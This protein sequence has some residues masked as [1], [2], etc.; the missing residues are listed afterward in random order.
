MRRRVACVCGTRPEVV[1]LAPVVLAMRKSTAIRPILVMS[2]QH[3][4]MLDQTLRWFDLKP[5]HDLDLMRAGQSPTEVTA[6]VLLG[7]E[8]V[9]SQLCPALVLVQGD[10][11]TA[12]SAALAAFFQKI[13]VGHVEAGLRT[14]DAY[15]PFPEEMA[16][17]LIGRLAS[18]HFAPTPRA[19]E[20][21]HREGVSDHVYMT[22]NT[23]VDALYQAAA[24][25]DNNPPDP[26][27]FGGA[28]FCGYRVLLVTA[29]RR[30]S[31]GKGIASISRAIRQIADE[32]PFTQV[33]FPLHS[34]PRVRETAV[35][36]LSGHPRI[37]L[38]EPLAYGPLVH[39]LSLCHLVMTDSGGIQEEA[40]TF[41]KPVLVLRAKT[42]RCEAVEAGVAKVVG[43][44][45]GAI[46]EA[47]RILL[48]DG[49][50]YTRMAQAVNPFGDGHAAQRIV[51]AIEH[52]LE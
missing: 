13:P 5:D 45:A 21:L 12:M 3:R 43:T 4:D 6:R 1:K 2:G 31:W 23:V 26:A 16:R 25:V 9:L 52:Y 37:F 42:E 22:G 50:T 51:R 46:V 36:I 27:M 47:A 41:G 20:L 38:V 8:T 48:T 28:D 49:E 33:L 24:V 40:A 19:V 35:P 30:E 32:F 34:N 10:T 14:N 39:A 15:D 7:M 11:V 44:D 29:H 18:L 17:R